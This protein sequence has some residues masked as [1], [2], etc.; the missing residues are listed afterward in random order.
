M[1]LVRHC[2]MRRH[3][4]PVIPVV[5]AAAITVVVLAAIRAAECGN[6][7]RPQSNSSLHRNNSSRCSRNIRSHRSNSNRSSNHN[8][9]RRSNSSNHPPMILGHPHHQ[10]M[11]VSGALMMSLRS[12]TQ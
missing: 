7:S 4:L 2:A 1:K 6:S 10:P 8:N 9:G 3:K 11:V 5:K 12:K